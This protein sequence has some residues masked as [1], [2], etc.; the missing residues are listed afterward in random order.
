MIDRFEKQFEV[1]DRRS[2]DK[3]FIDDSF[4]DGG[5]SKEC[6]QAATLVYFS[7]C[8][9]ANTDQRCW[10]S[11]TRIMDQH[12]MSK[13]TVLR[14]IR[15]L[16]AWNIIAVVRKKDP[17]TKR[18]MT[19]VY[20]LLNES[21]WKKVRVSPEN[22]DLGSVMT[23]G[24]GVTREPKPG[25]T[26]EPEVFPGEKDSHSEGSAAQSAA[27]PVR[28]KTEEG[29]CAEP[30]CL[31]K[32]VQIRIGDKWADRCSF[33]QPMNAEEF[34]E[35]FR[36]SDQRHIRIIAEFAD[37]LRLAGRA[38]D[39]RTVAQW[40]AWTDGKMM[41]HAKRLSVFDDDHL[42]KAMK[43]MMEAKYITEFN[44]ATLDNFVKNAQK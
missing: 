17:K 2:R 14:A 24:P 43:R 32:A 15:T 34:I 9:H 25:V 35:W 6:G 27:A 36:R 28:H 39:F 31:E 13:S 4:I 7:L 21:E 23:P 3:F 11:L 19:N 37:E 29:T 40:R 18:Q 1:R 16:E 5:Y 10:P 22:P 33:H 8:R 44:L 12:G 42:A 41:N 30:E 26:R 20:D 38:P